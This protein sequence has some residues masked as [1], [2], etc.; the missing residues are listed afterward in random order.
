[1]IQWPLI[2]YQ[3]QTIKFPDTADVWDFLAWLDE[4]CYGITPAMAA[5]RREDEAEQA[6]PIPAA[7]RKR[8]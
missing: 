1:M 3:G 2:Q 4:R 7:K 6:A 5:Q 8:K